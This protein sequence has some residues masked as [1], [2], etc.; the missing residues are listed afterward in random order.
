MTIQQTQTTSFK[1]E[2][3]QGIHD[4]ETDDI[5]IA[6]YTANASL[7]QST[8]EYTTSNEITDSGYT[9]GGQLLTDPV[10]SSSGYTAYVSFANPSWSGA[11]TARCALLYNA[12]KANRSVA[13][14]DFGSNKI[15]TSTFTITMP[16]NTA[17]SA[18]IR[19]SN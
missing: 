17:D 9:A 19:S 12:S 7:D 2:L 6:L 1:K 13:V 18:L 5:Y 16:A 14:I 15:S 10:V 3:Y 4:L 8:T 11:I